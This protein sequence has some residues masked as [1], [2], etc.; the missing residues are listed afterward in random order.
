MSALKTGAPK[1][2]P[3]GGW[4]VYNLFA[5]QYRPSANGIAQYTNETKIQTPDCVAAYQLPDCSDIACSESCTPPTCGNAGLPPCACAEGQVDEQGNCYVAAGTT[6]NKATCQKQGFKNAKAWKCWQGA[7]GWNSHDRGT[8]FNR[9]DDPWAHV[10][11]G[12]ATFEEL[13][14]A[15]DQNKYL[16]VDTGTVT[17]V[18]TTVNM[19]TGA[20]TGETTGTGQRK[21]EV[22][23]TSGNITPT[24]SDTVT[25]VVTGPN[26]RTSPTDVQALL[27]LAYTLAT[28]DQSSCQ[29]ILPTF[30]ALVSAIDFWYYDRDPITGDP[31]Y[32]GDNPPPV[33][34]SSNGGHHW[35]YRA[36][37]GSGGAR[38]ETESCVV[39]FDDHTMDHYIYG[40]E[41]A[42]GARIAMFHEKMTFG[43]A[44]LLYTKKIESYNT[45]LSGISV[46]TSPPLTADQLAALIASGQTSTRAL[47]TTS[48]VDFSAILEDVY[49]AGAATDG[50]GTLYGDAVH[51]LS[52]YDFT[53]DVKNP[54]RM[55]VLTNAAPQLHYDE[56]VFPAS[57]LGQSI[58]SGAT[59]PPVGTGAVIGTP[60]PA[61]YAPFYQYRHVGSVFVEFDE[62]SG[63]EI[64]RRHYGEFAPNWCIHC[65]EWTNEREI[66]NN[67]SG[68]FSRGWANGWSNG[69]LELQKWAEVLL[70]AKPSHN[71]ARPCGTDKTLERDQTAACSD[72]VYPLRWPTAPCYC[73]E[74]TN[75]VCEGMTPGSL[76]KWDDI[77][78]K[79]DFVSRALSYDNRAYSDALRVNAAHAAREA[80]NAG[81]P[82]NDAWTFDNQLPTIDTVTAPDAALTGIVPTD[83]C[84]SYVPCHPCVISCT[85]NGDGGDV[86]I[87]FPSPL[88]DSRY[89]GLAYVD[90]KQWMTDPL[91]QVPA[92]H[93]DE[94]GEGTVV[95]REDKTGGCGSGL[96]ATVG[97]ATIRYYSRRWEEARA[98]LPV[99]GA[100]TAPALPA[101]C[102][103]GPYTDEPVY[104]MIDGARGFA[105]WAYL[106]KQIATS[107]ADGEVGGTVD[108]VID[109]TL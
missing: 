80:Y 69:L 24:M 50:P 56:S 83:R 13:Q 45:D 74:P 14:S 64:W 11:S 90:V 4:S 15:P 62:Y 107:C 93:C 87:P 49:G 34:T 41:I 109:D 67:A 32:D 29:A 33:V 105:P 10:Y 2:P 52:L 97:G 60:T 21:Y 73:D 30:W 96:P 66:E 99:I 94:A 43:N 79:G 88:M 89:G 23:R 16:T 39:D 27:N 55:D 78:K 76:N 1:R 65:S 104:V 8:M 61:G 92:L 86:A 7:F 3:C 40:S 59:F 20:V 71:F 84:G 36:H 28:G 72:G 91:W 44:S 48:T 18:S 19:D 57:P 51:L 77:T 85:P 81:N 102:V 75:T 26:D 106:F 47:H 9:L 108:P 63:H 17:V 38:V 35:E 42:T 25:N 101:G 6:E 68:A 37:A 103:F 31:V 46:A 5:T 58:A 12:V 100:E 95:M 98:T 82:P 54:W 22:D 53:D 70:F